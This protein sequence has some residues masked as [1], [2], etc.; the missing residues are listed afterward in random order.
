M[1]NQEL[2]FVHKM[3]LA[4]KELRETRIWLL[5]IVSADLI[6]PGL[7]HHFGHPALAMARCRCDFSRTGP[8]LDVR[9]KSHLQSWPK[10]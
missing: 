1:L 8:V 5:I 10:R 9:L 2:V 7:D 6:K 3:R 4:L